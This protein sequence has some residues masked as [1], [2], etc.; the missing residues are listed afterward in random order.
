MPDKS[1]ITKA[2][3]ARWK[4]GY[5]D[6]VE[7]DGEW[8]DSPF[9]RTG[10]TTR[11]VDQWIQ[12]LFAGKTIEV[13]DHYSKSATSMKE[14][15]RANNYAFKRLM[16]RIDSE[17]KWVIEHIDFNPNAFTITPKKSLLAIINDRNE[18]INSIY[19]SKPKLS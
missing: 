6:T 14:V 17:H 19:K 2:L 9:R 12:D 10:R 8:I 1:K 5:D 13:F 16:N 3:K 7:V 15:F 18:K 4:A 11:Q